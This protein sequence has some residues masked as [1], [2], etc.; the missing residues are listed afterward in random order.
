MIL[1][2]AA[3]FCR[4]SSALPV[5]VCNDLPILLPVPRGAGRD[6]AGI[7]GLP[8]HPPKSSLVFNAAHPGGYHFH[9]K[10]SIFGGMETIELALVMVEKAFGPCP[11]KNRKHLAQTFRV[12]RIPLT[13]DSRESKSQ[14]RG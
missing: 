10:C 5:V 8:P 1:E 4:A 3:A 14:Q 2:A 6:L 9:C 12:V 7:D 13:S 11:A